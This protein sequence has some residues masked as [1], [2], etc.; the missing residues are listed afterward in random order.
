MF[1]PLL[2]LP[3]H[4]CDRRLWSFVEPEWISNGLTVVHADLTVG[5]SIEA[6]AAD[7]HAHAP[8]EFVAIG[9]SMGGIVAMEL[10][11]Q[12]PARLIAMVLTDTNASAELPERSVARL[13]Q[14]TKVKNGLLNEVV[15]EELKPA[16]L[17][18]ENRSRADLLTLT[19]EMAMDLGPEVFLRQ[20]EALRTRRDYRGIL[21]EISCPVQVLCGA[22]DPVCPPAWH[23]E[24]AEAIPGASL[25]LIGGA[26]HLP[27]LEQPQCFHQTVENWV[28]TLQTEHSGT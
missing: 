16:Y 5:S 23:E 17:A 27:P 18:P 7:V 4:M 13:T 21:S 20:S 25:E 10:Y 24:M 19:Y 3:G 8:D 28:R 9:L 12:A 26:G 14:Q 22:E 15:R 1:A 6:I 11:R 2:M